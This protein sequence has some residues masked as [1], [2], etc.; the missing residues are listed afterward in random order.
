MAEPTA[1]GLAAVAQARRRRR[2]ARV[3]LY[4]MVVGFTLM[5]A[6]PFLWGLITS[7]KAN[8]DLYNRNNNPFVFNRPPT[9]EHVR[10]LFEGTAFG[11]FVNN[12]V[13]V[14]L[15]VVAITLVASVPAAYSLARLKLRWG[16]AMGIAIFFV[17]L[18]PPSLLFISLSRV[19]SELG[20]QDSRWALVVV[21]PTITIPV[22]VW[23]LMG[24]FKSIPRDMEEQA[25]VDGYSR[26]GAFV[27]TVLPLSFPGLVAVVVFTATL[28]ASEFIYALAFVSQTSQKTV[29][30][31]VPTEL[32]RGDVFFW[33]SLQAATLLVA[34]PIALVFNA[35]LKRFIAGF[36][37]GAVKG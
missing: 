5:A 34:I 26:L 28:S 31:G 3:G 9:L 7:F 1:A 10:L 6:F 36:T 30:V 35:F 21:Y 19:V 24:F 18:I 29:S 16:G 8:Q 15:L 32:V 23:L 27:R 17:Y 12:T 13:V 4:A 25:M 14:A 2:W 20:L 37:M 11:T 33:Q 22:S